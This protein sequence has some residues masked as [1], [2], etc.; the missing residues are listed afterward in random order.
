M[1]R[2]W[3]QNEVSE[4][5]L[6]VVFPA[7]LWRRRMWNAL[8]PDMY[9]HFSRMVVLKKT[10]IIFLFNELPLRRMCSPHHHY[11]RDS[12]RRTGP[13]WQLTQTCS[14]WPTAGCTGWQLENSLL[15][16]SSVCLYMFHYIW[17]AFQSSPPTKSS[18][19]Q[20]DFSNLLLNVTKA[21]SAHS[22]W[23]Q[24]F[25]ST[26]CGVTSAKNSNVN[27]LHSFY[28]FFFN[29]QNTPSSIK[30]VLFWLGL[31]YSQQFFFLSYTWNNSNLSAPQR[32]ILS[33]NGFGL[34]EATMGT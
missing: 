25:V 18:F 32:I 28:I 27:I 16:R 29:I 23:P 22:L 6:T 15:D 33:P 8:F 13:D 12:R 20:Y 24:L 9:K 14:P 5:Q 3:Q 1:M 10:P 17:D 7:C 4:W 31:N 2:V 30:A 21:L 19:I 34:V 11:W 26:V